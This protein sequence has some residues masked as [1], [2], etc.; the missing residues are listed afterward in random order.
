MTRPYLVCALF[1]KAD[2]H[3]QTP[4]CDGVFSGSCLTLASG[5][6]HLDSDRI[7]FT[8]SGSSSFSTPRIFIALAFAAFRSSL[9]SSEQKLKIHFYLATNV[10]LCQ[11]QSLLHY[12]INIQYWL[13]H[14][15]I[16]PSTYHPNSNWQ[17]VLKIWTLSGTC[18]FWLE[19]GKTCIE[20]GSHPCCICS[21][22]QRT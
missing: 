4:T 18:R 1:S 12:A 10:T 13:F 17:S 22:C 8:L 3:S 15:L 19:I 21:D 5:D 2:I 7:D 14:C 9:F 11:L 20:T 6:T 16:Y